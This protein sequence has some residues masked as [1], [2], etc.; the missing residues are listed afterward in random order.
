MNR[1]SFPSSVVETQ[2][3]PPPARGRFQLALMCAAVLAV[4]LAIP[5]VNASRPHGPLVPTYLPA[6]EGPRER[7]PFDANRI[8]EL[9]Y[10]KPGSVIIGDSMAGSRIDDRRLG[11]LSGRP[12]ALLLQPGSG[13]A[14]WYLALKN[15]VITSGIHPHVVFVFFRDTNLTDVL[16][17]LDEQFRWSL[18]RVAHDRE[19]ELNAVVATRTNTPTRRL[20]MAAERVYEGNRARDWVEPALLTW[21]SRVL[22]PSRRHRDEFLAGMNERFGLEH[23]R[24]FEAADVQVSDED[25]AHFSRFVDRSVLP[26]M[27]RDAQAAGLTLCLVR[28]QRRP[29]GGKPP[30]QSQAMRRYVHDL[31]SYVQSH[32]GRLYD[33]TGDPELTIDMYGDGD[34]LVGGARRRYTDI[35]FNRLQRLFQ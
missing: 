24:P 17:R 23:Q 14:F 26:L 22:L 4:P 32:G 28:V 11:A 19:D 27:L 25:G 10:L 31:Q 9:K 6:L 35:F 15:W 34:H 3:V 7:L 5:L 18:D 13:S 2:S 29:V 30:V 16:F 21:P 33:E 1:W 20:G 12:S 8:E